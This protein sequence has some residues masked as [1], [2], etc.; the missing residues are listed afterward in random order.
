MITIHL[1]N[2]SFFAFHGMHPEE[3]IWGNEYEVNATISI[4]ATETIT[5]LEDTVDYA[6]VY[7]MI[8]ERM[9]IP[10]PLLETVAQDLLTT[11]HSNY[12]QARCI[13]IAICKK[14]PPI[15]AMQG[16][17]GVSCKKEY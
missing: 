14:Y 7:T 13:S 4:D 11:I 1:H 8:K 15:T 2:L 17:V 10:A 12:P 16:S 3:K 5:R 6:A 9:A